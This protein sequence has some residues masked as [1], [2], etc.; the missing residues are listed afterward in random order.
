MIRLLV[1][2][3]INLIALSLIGDDFIKSF[4]VRTR[5]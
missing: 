4:Q 2:V 5:G 3:L 1:L